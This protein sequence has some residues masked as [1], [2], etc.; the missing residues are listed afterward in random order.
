MGVKGKI[1][2]A[3]P[4]VTGAAEMHVGKRL[5]EIRK[6]AGITQLELAS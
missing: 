6:L 1:F 5:R 4:S 3:R 2:E